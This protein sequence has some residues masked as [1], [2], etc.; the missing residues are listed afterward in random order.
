MLASVYDVVGAEAFYDPNSQETRR[1]AASI[2]PKLKR[3]NELLEF[4]A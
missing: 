1:F 2:Y 4:R 3:L